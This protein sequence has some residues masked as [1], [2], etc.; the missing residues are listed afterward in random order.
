MRIFYRW[1]SSLLLLG[2]PAAAQTTDSLRQAVDH[3]FAPLD[4]SQVPAP[5][6]EEYGTRFASLTPY[7]GTLT[8][9]SVATLTTWRM[10]YA[11][12]VSGNVGRPSPCRCCPT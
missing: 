8:D 1:L 7:N 2:A 4:K 12:L 10:C 9:S 11:S 5:F 6:L 3:I